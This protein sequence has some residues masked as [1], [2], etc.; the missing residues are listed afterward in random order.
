MYNV[1]EGEEM[2]V[3]CLKGW[4]FLVGVGL[5]LL[6]MLDIEVFNI[7]LVKGF[8]FRLVGII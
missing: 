6:I 5:L 7:V 4:W 3:K 8:I 2:I 1:V